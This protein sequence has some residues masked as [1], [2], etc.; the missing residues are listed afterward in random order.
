M[1]N[2][3][4]SE[5]NLSEEQIA[6]LKQ[7]FEE[8]KTFNRQKKNYYDSV[9]ALNHDTLTLSENHTSGEKVDNQPSKKKKILFLVAVGIVCPVILGGAVYFI[10]CIIKKILI[11]R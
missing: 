8:N 9:S 11:I 10:I 5:L 2:I 3:D 6:E 7:K 1:G 4:L